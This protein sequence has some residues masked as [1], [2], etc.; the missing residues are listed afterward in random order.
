MVRTNITLVPS[1]GKKI[2]SLQQTCLQGACTS[3]YVCDVAPLT[4]CAFHLCVIA[5]F[6]EADVSQVEDACDDVQ[7]LD[8]NVTWDSDHLH[9]FLENIVRIHYNNCKYTFSMDLFEQKHQLG[10]KN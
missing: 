10:K 2:S 1:G 3:N 4:V 6:D 5:S 7:H 9:G 8:L